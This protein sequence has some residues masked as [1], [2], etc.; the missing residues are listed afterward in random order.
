MNDSSFLQ[1]RP[2]LA[3]CTTTAG[4]SAT[5]DILAQ[6]LVERKGWD[7]DVRALINMHILPPTYDELSLISIQLPPTFLS[8]DFRHSSARMRSN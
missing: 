3:Q 4:L 5:G 2:L 6:Q 7:H 1:R 8:G